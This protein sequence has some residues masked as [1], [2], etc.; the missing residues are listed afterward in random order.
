MIYT[1]T[2]NP[3]V[4]M[5]ITTGE[6]QPNTVMRT[7]ET[8][9]APQGKGI[10]VSF[11]LRHFGVE[12]TALGFFGGFTGEYI[13]NGCRERGVAVKPVWVDDMTRINVCV[14][15]GGQEYH[16]VNGGPLV[17]REKQEELL[18]LLRSL[19]DAEVLCISGSLPR[20]IEASYYEEVLDV[21]KAKDVPVVLDIS[22]PKLKEL[23]AYHPLLI[24]P[25][26]DELR[27]VF[28]LSCETEADVLSSLSELHRLGA[29]NVLLTLGERGAYFSNGKAV[30]R[31]GIYPVK[32]YS[33]VCAGDATLGGFLSRFL[34][35]N[36]V[37]EDA[38]KQGAA[39]GANA[40][41]SADLGDFAH[42]PVYRE[43]IDVYRVV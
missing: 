24:K 16:L 18:A 10:N 27:S 2:T 38:L 7:Q 29:Q 9:Y 6:W 3:A 8:V 41:E 37:I 14:N 26:D 25:N 36:T 43:R 1:L 22:S 34:A 13:V 31:S 12:N 30:Y 32:V 23:L 15:G 4:D 20:G 35:D 19:D 40:A 21:C 17:P 11:T 28:G 42:V 5:T 39:C 33:T